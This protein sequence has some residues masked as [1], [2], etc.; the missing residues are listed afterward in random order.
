MEAVEPGNVRLGSRLDDGIHAIDD[1]FDSVAVLDCVWRVVGWTPPR[2]LIRGKGNVGDVCHRGWVVR[3]NPNVEKEGRSE[4]W[5]LTC[6]VLNA[7]RQKGQHAVTELIAAQVAE[8]IVAQ[9]NCRDVSRL[10]FK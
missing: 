5:K 9:G 2:L 1:T 10:G 7:T 4:R 6:I 8:L 3:I